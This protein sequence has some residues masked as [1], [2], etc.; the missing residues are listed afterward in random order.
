MIESERE[1]RLESTEEK[2]GESV[3]GL[4][5]ALAGA[6]FGSAAG[7]VGTILG[8]LAGAAGGWWAGEKVG[9]AIDEWTD[10]DELWARSHYESLND[11]DVPEYDVARV[12]YATGRIAARNP[13]YADRDY[14]VIERDLREGWGWTE[15]DYE[16]M[17]PYVRAAYDR[18]RRALN[19]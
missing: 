1:N 14:A 13:D 3:G 8:G 18:E 9:R 7:P 5:G 16:T 19:V 15:Y 12:G 6:G 10:E 4:T 2:V 11:P 17:R